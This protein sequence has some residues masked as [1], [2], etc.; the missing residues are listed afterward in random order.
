MSNRDKIYRGPKVH[1][2]R[3]KLSGFRRQLEVMIYAETDSNWGDGRRIEGFK[4]QTSSYGTLMK[5]DAKR[6]ANAMSKAARRIE[7]LDKLYRGAL[8]RPDSK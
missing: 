6:Y 4:M 2:V 7:E 3:F 5:N 1:Y 8:Y